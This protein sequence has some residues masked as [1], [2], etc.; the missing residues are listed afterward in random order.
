MATQK[1]VLEL[2]ELIYEA[3]VDASRWPRFLAAFSSALGGSATC[4]TVADR[5][6][7]ARLMA[8]THG[9]SE[10]AVRD[11][12]NHYVAVDPFQ[13]PIQHEAEGKMEFGERYIPKSELERTEIF[14]DWY[15]PNGLAADSLGG[16]VMRRD[17]VPS[18]LGVYR[19]RSVRPLEGEDRDLA[20]LLMPHLKRALQIHCRLGEAGA[21]SA[22]LLATLDH[23]AFGVVLVDARGRV[24]ATNRAAREIASRKDGIVLGRGEI[25]ADR[26]SDTTA[27]RRLVADVVAS[28]AAR[29]PGAGGIVVVRRSPPRRPLALLVSP[30][31]MATDVGIPSAAG[32]IFI[33]DLDDPA[34]VSADDLRDLYGLTP[35]QAEV[36]AQ[37]SAGR[38]L[39]EVSEVLGISVNTVKVRLQEVFAKT[40]THRQAE[41]SRILARAS[42]I[43]RNP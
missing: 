35:R 20:S 4:L 12:A 15:R 2:I 11:H 25:R 10:T 1:T 36:A 40:E 5:A 3:A 41:L 28:G 38:T 7:G 24:V 30:L 32:V 43:R 17:G 9:L 22:A 6:P 19:P 29:A 21:T 16:V 37:L 27:I 26:S 42:S 13:D 14:N 34:P 31:R 8:V 39:S 23:L 18:I 33:D